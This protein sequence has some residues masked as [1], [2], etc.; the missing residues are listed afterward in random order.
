MKNVVTMSW[1]AI[2]AGVLLIGLLALIQLL[3]LPVPIPASVALLIPD[4]LP[5]DSPFIRMWKDSALEEGVRLQPVNIK[6]WGRTTLWR[7]QAWE[8]VILPDTFHRRVDDSVVTLLRNYVAGGGHLMLVYDGGL[9]TK[10]G[11]YHAHRSRFSDLAGVDFGMYEE[12]G[13]GLAQISRVAMAP[14]SVMKRLHIPPGRFASEALTFPASE[15]PSDDVHPDYP[16]QIFDYSQLPQSF[17]TLV[18]RGQAS[19]PLMRS[20]DGGTLAG[21]QRFGKGETLL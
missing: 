1:V 16:A 20:E 15:H 4:D 6:D 18:T 17:A 11:Y 12:L 8:G 13:E 9:L 14:A 5:E 10:D 2:T 21:R 19:Q 3:R 7:G